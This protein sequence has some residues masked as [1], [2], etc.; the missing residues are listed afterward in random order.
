MAPAPAAR[1]GH[2][3]RVERCCWF[4]QL[5][6][7]PWLVNLGL[8]YFDQPPF[9]QSSALA[10]VSETLGEAE[11]AAPLLP[12]PPL[13]LPDVVSLLPVAEPPLPDVLPLPDVVPLPVAAPPPAAPPLL[14]VDRVAEPPPALLSVAV[15]PVAEPLP[16]VGALP[17]AMPV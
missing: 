16:D 14:D 11:P 2:L 15:P 6:H 3:P 4:T 8:L 17:M 9:R 13:A 12:L 7:S 1:S 10:G 5:T